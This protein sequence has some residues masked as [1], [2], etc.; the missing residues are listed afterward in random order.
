MKKSP[1]ALMILA[2][3]ALPGVLSA[4]GETAAPE[5]VFLGRETLRDP[6]VSDLTAPPA[7][8]GLLGARL[9]LAD[10]LAATKFL[11]AEKRV[12]WRLD[13][14]ALEA[15][16][17][18][19][20]RAAADHG[21]RLFIADLPADELLA[22]ADA[23]RESGAVILNSGA[24]D[25]RLR[26]KDCRANLLHVAPSQ[27]M[28]A[29][30]LMQFLVV[31]RWTRALLLRGAHDEDVSVAEAFQASAKKYGVKIVAEKIWSEE[32]EHRRTA[33]GDAPAATQGPEHDVVL[34]ADA[35]DH[36]GEAIA[37][38]TYAA[39]PVVGTHGLTPKIW[40]EMFDQW[41]S[42]QL[43]Q[44]FRKLSGRAM[45]EKDWTAWLAVRAL[46]QAATRAGSTD[47]AAVRAALRND[48][49]GLDGFKGRALNFRPWNGQLRQPIHLV[50][51]HA[52]VSVSPQ[53]GFLNQRTDLDTLGEDEQESKC[54]R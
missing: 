11:P 34:V 20:A 16:A 50:Q 19:A 47:A 4:R 3:A 23:L 33:A 28:L 17:V 38:N 24:L 46:T 48:A 1:R 15:D 39:R 5:I 52:V 37:Y 7:D 13:T 44:R 18:A 54:R 14:P 26:G 45:A 27:D 29:D 8:Q 10:S 22:V 9:G 41:G 30:A 36:F 35:L 53:D 42:E 6:F 32:S 49:F 12:N 31:K 2:L 21:A 43:Q 51:P 25:A 40:G